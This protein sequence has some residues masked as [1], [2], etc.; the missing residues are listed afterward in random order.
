MNVVVAALSAP[1]QLNGVSR[2]A[3]NLPAALLAAPG[4]E[5][6]HFLCGDWQKSIFHG[7]VKTRDPRL[8]LHW[9]S[10]RDVNFNRLLW[11]Y[12]ELPQIAAQL[13][14][15]I[16][17]LAH[18][19][20]VAKNAFPCPVVL[21]L[22]DLYPFDIPENFGFLKG[23]FARRIVAQCLRRVDAIACV[24]ASTRARLDKWFPRQLRK[25]AVVPN[26]VELPP[27]TSH[28][29]LEP[30]IGRTFVLCVAQHRSNKNV[31][32][33]IQAFQRALEQEILHPGARIAIV[34]IP[35]PETKRIQN[36]IREL[37]LSG[38]V[39][40]M[41]GLS[42][43]QLRWCY[44]N[45]ALLLAPSSIE[46]FGLPVAEAMLAGCRVVCSDIPAFRELRGDACRF[47]G[48]GGDILENYTEAIRDVLALP[49]PSGLPLPQ[50]SV[51]AVGQQY[52]ALYQSL[53]CSHLSEFDMLRQPEAFLC[54]QVLQE[55]SPPLRNCQGNVIFSPQRDRRDR[56]QRKMKP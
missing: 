2:H 52:L 42:D 53:H 14:A 32:L 54:P 18:P 43:A 40:L 23:A 55:P 41:S 16:V 13:D 35:G 11:Y 33:A 3:V 46:G 38:R 20:P 21:S 1:S 10:L 31:P 26:I 29:G 27:A 28:C 30:L 45:C 50:L 7:A 12:F 48:W 24:S 37:R 15:E 5:N 9:I 51:S 34:G 39:L 4:I 56:I 44:E 17:H 8:H 22:H 19:A 47:V 49:K 25:A 6:I 36:L